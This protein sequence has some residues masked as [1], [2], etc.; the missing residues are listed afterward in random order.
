M[1]YFKITAVNSTIIFSWY[2]YYCFVKCLRSSELHQN[3]LLGVWKLHM[4]TWQITCLWK[5][6][7]YLNNAS[8]VFWRKWINPLDMTWYCASYTYD[9]RGIVHVGKKI[10][11]HFTSK[12]SRQRPFII[13]IRTITNY[14][15]PMLWRK[16]V[17]T[18][19]DQ[20]A[21]TYLDIC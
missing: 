11:V 18:V 14:S 8:K 7:F 15:D 5:G 20:N 10:N 4:N 21:V 19:L 6:S 13:K 3:Y 17:E 12:R 16:K 2:F 9:I 1:V